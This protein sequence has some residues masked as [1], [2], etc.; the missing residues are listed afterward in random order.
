MA[1]SKG[2]AEEGMKC[3]FVEF[4]EALARLADMSMDEKTRGLNVPLSHKLSKVVEKLVDAHHDEI[5]Q[6]MQQLS[7]ASKQVQKRMSASNV[8]WGRENTSTF[9]NGLVKWRSRAQNAQGKE[10]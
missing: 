2:L 7:K 6:Y 4:L 1:N 9:W 3:S 5:N 8:K 10:E